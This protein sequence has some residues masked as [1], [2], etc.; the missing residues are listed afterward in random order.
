MT[1]L[2]MFAADMTFSNLEDELSKPEMCKS[3]WN[4]SGC[5]A[6][7]YLSLAVFTNP[8]TRAIILKRVHQ[9]FHVSKP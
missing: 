4:T 9:S 7:Q 2:V 8:S 3:V 1:C 6:Q 5:G